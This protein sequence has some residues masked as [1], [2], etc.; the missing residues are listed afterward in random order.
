MSREQLLATTFV[1]LADTLGEGFDALDFLQNLADRAVEILGVT[2]AGVVLLDPAGRLQLVATTSHAAQVLELFALAVSEGPCLHVAQT[3]QDVINLAP[4]QARDRWPRFT[5]AAEGLGI[6]TAHVVPLR[7]RSDVLGALSLFDRGRHRLD[8]VDLAIVR[9]LASV[10]TIGLLQERSPHQQATIAQQ[11]SS[12]LQRRVLLEQ[13]KGMVAELGG[14]DM[15]ASFQLLLGYSRRT[16]EPLGETARRVA[17]R[18]L[19]LADL[20]TAPHED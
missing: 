3:G 1:E 19:D 2:S 4:G 12:A 10:A 7:L 8:T 6:G 15:D 16:G 14:L 9:A 18:R 17:D 20:L 11:L 13:A 5:E